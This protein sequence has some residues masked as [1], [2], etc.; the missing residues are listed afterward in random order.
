VHIDA[1]GARGLVGEMVEVA[2]TCA[3][4]HSLA[5]ELTRPLPAPVPRARPAAALRRLP[6]Y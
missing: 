5:G 4:R 2:I 6:L 3:H 1:P